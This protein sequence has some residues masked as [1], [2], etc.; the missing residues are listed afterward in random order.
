MTPHPRLVAVPGPNRI[1]PK[2]VSKQHFN[3]TPNSDLHTHTHTHGCGYRES[4]I[5]KH[6][7]L[8]PAGRVGPARREGNW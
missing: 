8:L 4:S 5:G 7:F 1:R 2:K 6:T 3:S